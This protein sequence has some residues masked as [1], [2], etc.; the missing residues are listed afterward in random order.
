MPEDLG[1]KAIDDL[2]K[3]VVDSQPGIPD[4]RA[5]EDWVK[6]IVAQ[7]IRRNEEPQ[8]QAAEPEPGES[9]ARIDRGDVGEYEPILQPLDNVSPLGKR[10]MQPQAVDRRVL[11]R[12]RLIQEVFPAF[13]RK[14]HA[15]ADD[16]AS[17]CVTQL[18]MTHDDPRCTEARAEAVLK[19]VELSG[20]PANMG[21][22]GLGDYTAHPQLQIQR[23]RKAYGK[24][25]VIS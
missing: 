20:A 6:P 24:E 21:G 19:M 9:P 14:I 1:R 16:A 25:L 18:G 7:T 10:H 2:T 12:L 11:L 8:Q 22:L 13:A 4:T 15:A 5:I 17:R 23:L 3:R